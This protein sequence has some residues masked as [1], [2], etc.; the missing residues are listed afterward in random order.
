METIYKGKSL[1]VKLQAGDIIMYR[2][3]LTLSP[4]TWLSTAIRK[5]T[6][7]PYNHTAVITESNGALYINEALG[8]GIIK[9]PLI[10]NLGKNRLEREQ[11]GTSYIAILR[12]RVPVDPVRFS[13]Y[14]DGFLGRKYDIPALLFHHTVHRIT[15][16]WRGSTGLNAEGKLV[17]SEFAQLVHN[18]PNFWFASTKEVGNDAEYNK[19][20][21]EEKPLS[22]RAVE[23]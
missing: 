8:K 23:P 14:A 15:G 6:D 11:H 13:L 10:D 2:N 20:I 16:E 1:P 4:S 17:C 3:E 19:L 18:R 21:W 12:P 7:Y 5:F 9:R 22:A